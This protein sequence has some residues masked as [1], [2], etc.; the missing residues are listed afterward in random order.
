VYRYALFVPICT[1]NSLILLV[2]VGLQRGFTPSTGVQIPQGA[3]NL[4]TTKPA[5][6]GKALAGFAFINEFCS[7][8]TDK[9]R[10]HLPKNW[11]LSWVSKACEKYDTQV[12]SP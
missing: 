8:K 12:A 6:D 1:R 10:L 11:V 3:P 2:G 9:D 5:K 4:G 7:P